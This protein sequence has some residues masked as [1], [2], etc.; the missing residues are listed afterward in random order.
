MS[1]AQ[2]EPP[3]KQWYP[4]SRKLTILYISILIVLVAAML[5]RQSSLRTLSPFTGPPENTSSTLT[6][7]RH[8]AVAILSKGCRPALELYEVSNKPSLLCT[9][10]SNPRDFTLSS[11]GSYLLILINE[12]N[13]S[14][15]SNDFQVVA[16]KNGQSN[17]LMWVTESG[18]GPVVLRRYISF[19]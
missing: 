5:I 10:G 19:A 3:T 18:R 4:F 12:D 16:D 8:S 2:I 15:W 6:V 1:N 11:R 14:T 13:D 7:P 17:V 9:F